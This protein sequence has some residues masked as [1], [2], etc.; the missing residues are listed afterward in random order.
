MNT[1]LCKYVPSGSPVEVGLLNFAASI[2]LDIYEKMIARENESKFTLCA[3]LPFASERQ[4]MTVAYIDHSHDETLVKVIMKGSPES[5]LSR[6]TKAFDQ[7]GQENPIEVHHTMQQ[8]E[9]EVILHEDD[10]QPMGL[11]AISFAQKILD[12]QIFTQILDF[13]N[14]ENRRMLESDLTYI[15]TVGLS[16]PMREGVTEAVLHLEETKTN[17]RIFSGDHEKAVIATAI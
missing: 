1:T 8:I 10:G 13:E 6:S 2:G 3:W 4:C 7:Y 9:R 15:G 12:R 14:E 17:V 11:K 16:D 5:V